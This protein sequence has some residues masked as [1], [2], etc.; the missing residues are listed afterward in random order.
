MAYIS[1]LLL[2][3]WREKKRKLEILFLVVSMFEETERSFLK[4]LKP[5][6][7]LFSPYRKTIR[8]SRIFWNQRAMRLCYPR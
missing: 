6:A 4:T 3:N 2:T 1:F 8:F 5:E 7:A